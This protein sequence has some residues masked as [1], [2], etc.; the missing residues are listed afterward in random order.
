MLKAEYGDCFLITLKTGE[1]L[2]MN[3]LVDGGTRHT[4]KAELKQTLLGIIKKGERLD[5]IIVTHIDEDHISGIISLFEDTEFI[6]ELQPKIVIYNFY[7]SQL[8]EKSSNNYISY[9]QGNILSEL[10]NKYNKREI[11]KIKICQVTSGDVLDFGDIKIYIL[12]PLPLHIHALNEEWKKN[13]NQI[14]ACINDYQLSIESFDDIDEA[15]SSTLTNKSSIS[16]IMSCESQAILMMGDAPPDIIY[17]QLLQK[18]YSENNPLKL[19]AIKLSHHGGENSINSKLLSIIE[20]NKFLI[21]TNGKRYKHPRKRTLVQ[22]LK[23][24]ANAEFYL[25]Y[26]R[27]VFTNEELA[28]Y[29]IAYYEEIGIINL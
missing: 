25:N 20:C 11:H 3:V 15:S 24:N 4:Y 13:R 18:N 10:I 9:K 21:S 2:V 22:I 17:E 29:N 5:I 1:G 8:S 23:T 12:S 16:F 7:D 26:K 14:S 6:K 27:D 19:S 28:F